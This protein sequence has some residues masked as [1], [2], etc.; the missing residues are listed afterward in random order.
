MLKPYT[1]TQKKRIANNIIKACDDI[2]LLNK[3]AYKFLNLCSGFIAHY[4]LNGFISHYSTYS[5]ERDIMDNV[6]F[7]QWSN[8]KPTDRDYEY[9]MSKKDIYNMIVR[10]IQ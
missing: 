2:E 1:D 5:L 10:E 4:D 3:P 6:R 8:F 9:M 7:N